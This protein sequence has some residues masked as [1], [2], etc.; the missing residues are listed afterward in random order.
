MSSEEGRFCF[1]CEWYDPHAA[2][3]RRYQLMYYERDGTVEMFDIKN[4]RMFL[5]KTQLDN[6]KVEDLYIGSNVCILSR[7]MNFVDYGDDYTRSRLSHKKERTLGMIKP[8][9]VSKLG[10][11]LDLIYQR[12][13]VMTKLKC[14]K[15]NRNEAFQFYQEHQGKLFFDNLLNFV[16]SGPVV[17]F[18]MMGEGSI[19]KWRDLLGP[20]D[21]AVAR[22]DAATSIRARFGTDNTKNACHGSDSPQSAARELEFFFPSTGA[23][24]QDTSQLSDCTC[25]VIKPHAVKAGL[26]G[27]IISAIQEAGFEISMV[28][29][30]HMEKAD[31]EE[32]HE[33]YKGV[34]QEYGS[35]VGELTSGPCIA[36]EIRAADAV[37]K[38]R[39]AVGP[40]DPEIA[41]HLRPRTLRALFGTDK[42]R[43]AVHCTD[44]PEDGILEVEYFFRILNH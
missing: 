26:A 2:F 36:M 12:G 23:G 22:Q 4:H 37:N 31:A 21:S 10:Q 3:I 7:Q 25:C 17:A 20:T 16:T 5:K 44:L 14:C 24:R 33:V 43:N 18:E 13:F 41:R 30:F 42:I 19:A 11:I 40:T 34:V 27:K 8:D 15:L 6:L 32:F 9:A 28:E 29:M 35:M 38:F 1:I 39:E